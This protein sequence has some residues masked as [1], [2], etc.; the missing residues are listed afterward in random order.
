[1]LTDACVWNEPDIFGW[2]PLTL[3]VPDPVIE[4]AVNP[5]RLVWLTDPVAPPVKP[6]DN[7][8]EK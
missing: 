1:M 3:N 8:G 5:V 6:Y 7:N 4:P 2:I